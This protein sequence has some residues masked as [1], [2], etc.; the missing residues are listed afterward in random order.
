MSKLNAPVALIIMD[1]WGV[2]TMF[3]KTSGCLQ[4]PA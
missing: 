4:S 3:L 1:G 2:G